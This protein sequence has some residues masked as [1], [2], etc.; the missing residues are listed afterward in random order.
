[1]PAQQRRFSRSSLKWL[2]ALTTVGLLMGLYYFFRPPL[3]PLGPPTV[4]SRL[5]WGAQAPDPRLQSEAGPEVF[6]T[7]VIHHSAM[8]LYEGPRDIQY[9]HMHQ[10]GFL[11]IGYHFVI[12]G[13]GRIYE[14]RSLAVH[15]AHV[16]EHNAGTLGIVLMGNYEEIVPAAEPLARLKWLIRELMQRY[17]ITHLAG[18]RDFLPGQTVCPGKNLEPLLPQL[19]ADLGLQFGAGGY[20]GPEPAAGPTASPAVSPPSLSASEASSR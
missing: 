11:D 4:I 12:D 18:H 10:R 9:T 17:P 3:V 8:Q 13:W 20:S 14:G 19:A 1:M 15:G 5:E 7:I 6:N 2:A 16:K